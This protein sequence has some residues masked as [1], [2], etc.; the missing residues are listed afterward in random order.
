MYES[1]I[2][3]TIFVSVIIFFHRIHWTM[4]IFS[5]YCSI[6][7]PPLWSLVPPACPSSFLS[8]NLKYFLSKSQ[9]VKHWRGSGPSSL[10]AVLLLPAPLCV[11]SFT[12]YLFSLMKSCS[13]HLC[14]GLGVLQAQTKR[15]QTSVHTWDQDSWGHVSTHCPRTVFE[16]VSVCARVKGALWSPDH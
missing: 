12:S 2:C 16:G 15:S 11:F 9:S 5:S 8:P 4:T 6:P 1:S 10:K 7:I 14:L 13:N 3:K